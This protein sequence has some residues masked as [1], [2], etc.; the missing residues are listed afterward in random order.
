MKPVVGTMGEV[1]EKERSDGLYVCPISLFYMD[2]TRR[3][4][5]TIIRGRHSESACYYYKRDGY[6]FFSAKPYNLI[7]A[8]FAGAFKGPYTL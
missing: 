5:T 3:M 2:G 8:I 6:G 4:P 1:V 7:S